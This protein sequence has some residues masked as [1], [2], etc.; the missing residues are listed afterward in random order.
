MFWE[1]KGIGNLLKFL[2]GLILFCNRVAVRPVVNSR[3]P[4]EDDLE[5]EAAVLAN[6]DF[7]QNDVEDEEDNE[8]DN[9]DD[10]GSA[11]DESDDRDDLRLGRRMGKRAKQ[12]VV[13]LPFSEMQTLRVRAKLALLFHGVISHW[14]SS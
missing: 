13:P 6:F 1:L 12:G 11:D 5:T 10:G 3:A 2:S 9:D 14:L 8:D 4:I 7:L